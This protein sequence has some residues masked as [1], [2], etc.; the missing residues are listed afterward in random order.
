LDVV[1]LEALG[2]VLCLL[3][4]AFFSGSETALTSLSGP[5]THKL[6][7]EKGSR[8]LQL[9]LDR[10]IQV[11]TTILIGNN[12]VNTTASA[13]ATDITNR[14]LAGTSAS[15]WAI[16]AAVF[17]IT[18]LLLTFGEITPKAIAKRGSKQIGPIAMWLLRVPYF[19]FTP[20][21][22][23]FTR[24]T[25]WTMRMLGNDI[26]A[27]APFV[28]AEEIEYMID[29]GSREGS[30]P[31]A[32]ERM[33]RTVFELND[34]VVREIMVPRTNMIALPTHASFEETLRVV[35]TCGHSRIP[36][37]KGSTDNII[38]V[39][40]VKDLIPRLPTIS[41]EQF[42]LIQLIRK[43]VFVP[44]SKRLAD[45]LAEFQ[46]QRI[47]MAILVDEFGGTAGLITLEDIVEEFFGEI[48]DE[49]DV[50]TDLILR[51][52]DDTLR[53]DARA[54]IY[55]IEEFFEKDFPDE[56]EYDT[57]GGFL[58][59]QLGT[60]PDT[61][62]EVRWENLVFRVLEADEKRVIR[63][64]IERFPDLAEASEATGS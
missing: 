49:Y 28:T 15:N 4:S 6:I 22:A 39:F 7:E 33:L 45:M 42:S 26:H 57:V 8:S 20:F 48:R 56:I 55:D 2:I 64:E 35:A 11:L 53:T 23:I 46:L 12:I 3:L 30:F 36:V 54:S 19:L 52:D 16:P 5:Q 40:Y 1:I 25:Q 17:I 41:K 59:A 61:G 27:H 58:M 14:L 50:E 9:W 43:P 24:V 32:H 29:L 18:L 63:V 38:G 44:E 21:T 37:Y 62:E 60:V 51:I 13:L 31:E 34:T 47:H 10:P